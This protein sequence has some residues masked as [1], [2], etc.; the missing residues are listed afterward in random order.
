MTLP[1]VFIAKNSCVEIYIRKLEMNNENERRFAQGSGSKL[2]CRIGEM[3]ISQGP[4]KRQV[5]ATTCGVRQIAEGKL[6][7]ALFSWF[8][9]TIALFLSSYSS[10]IYLSI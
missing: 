7:S 5:S 1:L 3:K 6:S 9:S 2:Q 8:S 10:N 4:L